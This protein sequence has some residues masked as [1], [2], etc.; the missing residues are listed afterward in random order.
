M[1]PSSRYFLATGGRSGVWTKNGKVEGKLAADFVQKMLASKQVFS[2]Y[3]YGLRP[4]KARYSTP[5]AG[6]AQELQ[7]CV[8]RLHAA[9]TAPPATA[10]AQKLAA[11]T[12]TTDQPPEPEGGNQTSSPSGVEKTTSAEFRRSLNDYY[13]QP[14][15]K[16]LALAADPSGNLVWGAATGNST[17]QD[18]VDKA[19]ATCEV[20]RHGRQVSSECRVLLVNSA[21]VG[22]L[23]EGLT[24]GASVPVS[25]DERQV[26]TSSSSPHADLGTQAPASYETK[27]VNGRA[28]VVGTLDDSQVWASFS[29]D[30]G[31]HVLLYLV[32]ETGHDIQFDPE[33]VSATAVQV[34]KGLSRELPMATF[35]AEAYEQ[36]VRRNNALIAALYG[37]STAV[38]NQPQTRTSTV[39]GSTQGSAFTGVVTTW[40]S[41]QDY[42]QAQARTQAQIAAM[43]RQLESNLDSMATTLARK[44]TL[45]SGSFYGGVVHFRKQRASTYKIN[46]PFGQ[47]LYSARFS[48]K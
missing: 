37:A 35:S 2:G 12:D 42:A 16:A 5:L 46:V 24:S 14:D 9:N 45:P 22:E 34:S 18:A 21:R 8:D 20:E 36:K 23:P 48:A 41:Q 44:H 39:T 3:S 19:V 26:Y 31:P 6:F 10:P 1:P 15:E 30:G 32:N 28:F 47:L 40:P 25:V 13:G 27:W 17:I 7:D 4:M 33:Q 38:S 29:T 43:T 11:E